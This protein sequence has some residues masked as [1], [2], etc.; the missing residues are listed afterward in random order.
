[1][2]VRRASAASSPDAYPPATVMARCA[3]PAD[4]HRVAGL[5]VD[6]RRPARAERRAR[7]GGE[8]ERVARPR[9]DAHAHAARASA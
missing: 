1:M 4:D 6:A 3:A 8:L 7:E 5:L 9:G 2:T